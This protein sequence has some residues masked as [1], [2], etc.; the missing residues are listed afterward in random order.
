MFAI[1]NPRYRERLIADP[2]WV[3]EK[4]LNKTLGGI[5]VKA[6]VETPDMLYVVVPHIPKEGEIADADLEYVQ[7]GFLDYLNAKCE[8]TGGVNASIVMIT[9]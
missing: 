6:V 3:L 8:V 4:Q 7:G 9:L 2:K 5:N 1:E